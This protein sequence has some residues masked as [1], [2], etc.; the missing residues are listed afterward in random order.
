MRDTQPESFAKAVKFDEDLR[1][2]DRPGFGLRNKLYLHRSL[3]PLGEADL[4]NN[5]SPLF[6][7]ECGGVCGV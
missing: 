3:S 5:N 7:Q 2:L 4:G 1:Q 6:D